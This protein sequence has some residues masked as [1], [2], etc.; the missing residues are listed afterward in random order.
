VLQFL[1]IQLCSWC[2]C[3]QK[4]TFGVRISAKYSSV[5][6]MATCIWHPFWWL[7]LFCC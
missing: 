5:C 6:L 3:L 4:E 2:F 7:C 1:L